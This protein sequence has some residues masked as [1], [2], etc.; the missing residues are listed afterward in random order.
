[1]TR[2]DKRATPPPL[3]ARSSRH[4]IVASVS[5]GAH[6]PIDACR[7]VKLV[8]FSGAVHMACFGALSSLKFA[9]GSV[10]VRQ[11]RLRSVVTM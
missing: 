5:F 3:T 8:M 1:M 9:V 6:L 7:L 10:Q 4:C 2:G 11:D